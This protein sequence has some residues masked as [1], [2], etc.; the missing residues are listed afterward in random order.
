MYQL[1]ECTRHLASLETTSAAYKKDV[2]KKQSASTHYRLTKIIPNERGDGIQQCKFHTVQLHTSKPRTLEFIV[3][4]HGTHCKT[5]IYLIYKRAKW[6]EEEED[7]ERER[8]RNQTT[9]Q[10]STTKTRERVKSARLLS[11]PDRRRCL[12]S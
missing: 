7:R 11:S 12:Q 8:E 9:L 3:R 1:V 4:L 6:E 5:F 10:Q 2:T